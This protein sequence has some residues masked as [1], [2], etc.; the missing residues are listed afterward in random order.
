MLTVLFIFCLPKVM[1]DNR[2]IF[3]MDSTHKTV[4]SISDMQ[5]EDGRNVSKSA[6]LFTLLVKDATVHK[7]IPVAFMV[8]SSESQ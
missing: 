7:G 6:Y 5:Q 8:S 4:S 1:A 2:D 3:C